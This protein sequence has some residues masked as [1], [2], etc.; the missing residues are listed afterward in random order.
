MTQSSITLFACLLL[1]QVIYGASAFTRKTRPLNCPVNREM[2]EACSRTIFAVG[3]RDQYIPK[4]NMHLNSYCKSINEAVKC[5]EDYNRCLRGYKRQF[6]RSFVSY[7]KK[8]A[9]ESC[10]PVQ[11]KQLL[12]HYTCLAKDKGTRTLQSRCLDRHVR[13]LKYVRDTVSA[14]YQF[15]AYCCA[16]NT[17]DKCVLEVE[18]TL[19]DQRQGV[20]TS[21]YI[22]HKL[23]MAEN[24]YADISN[25]HKLCNEVPRD[26]KGALDAIENAYDDKAET[27]SPV[28]IFM[29]IAESHARK[30]KA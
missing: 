19:C 2:A 5:L 6:I 28:F 30:T 27:E 29:D 15:G 23:T 25:C 1:V 17:F 11:S 13:S 24:S 21:T 4:S 26:T 12:N 8:D 20:I 10:D 16:R 22:H 18:A 14:K 9:D 7:A 3:N